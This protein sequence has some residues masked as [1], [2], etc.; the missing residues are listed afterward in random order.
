MCIRDSVE[1]VQILGADIT[2]F[3]TI[4][5]PM[6]LKA[7]GLRQAD[8]YF[9]HGLLMMK[10]GK[11]SKSKGNVIDPLPLIDKYGVDAVRYYLAREV[12]F[13]NDGQ[14]TPEQFVERFNVD[15]VNDFGNLLNRTVSMIE[16]Y[17]DGV[18]PLYRGQVTEFDTEIEDLADV[19]KRQNNT[20]IARTI[21]SS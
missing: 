3:H 9:V 16:K 19:Y 18:I 7:L 14:F 1:I 4:Y 20:L 12:V 21:F 8:R 15:L 17:C 5:W 13:G 11:M 2:R 6:I 10:D